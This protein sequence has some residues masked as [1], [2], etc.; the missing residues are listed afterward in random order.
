MSDPQKIASVILEDDEF[1]PKEYALDVDRFSWKHALKS[2]GF[3]DVGHELV[4]YYTVARDTIV[5]II[6]WRPVAG[7]DA[8]RWDVKFGGGHYYFFLTGVDLPS[9]WRNLEQVE[10]IITA[11]HDPHEVMREL[12]RLKH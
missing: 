3:E 7:V 4:K 5:L 8:L 6:G 1:D 10:A 2:H 11:A 9:V 12:W